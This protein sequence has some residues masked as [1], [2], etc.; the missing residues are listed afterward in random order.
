MSMSARASKRALRALYGRAS[1]GG[2]G[3]TSIPSVDGRTTIA[4]NGSVIIP[5]IVDGKV[6]N[7]KVTIV[8]PN[9]IF[10]TLYEDFIKE[11]FSTIDKSKWKK[12]K[13]KELAA[14]NAIQKD[15]QTGPL[16]N[17][18]KTYI[19]LN[20]EEKAKSLNEEINQSESIKRTFKVEIDSKGNAGL[21]SIKKGFISFDKL[22]SENKLN[23][24]LVAYP[25]IETTP[26]Y[27]TWLK[28]QTQ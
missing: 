13:N 8:G 1:I 14:Y 5:K 22:K 16:A 6:T 27:I 3:Q 4:T 25:W 28:S 21:N 2:D 23:A 15:V 11:K 10:K 18:F 12:L 24:I 19:A 7:E 9:I 20:W 17:E 26:E